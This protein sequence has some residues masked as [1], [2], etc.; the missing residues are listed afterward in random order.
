MRG[1]RGDLAQLLKARFPV[2]Y[3]ESYEEQRVVAEVSA[4]AR[5]AA[6]LR[7]PRTVWTWSATGG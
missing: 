5:D 3:I 4:V 1:F 2:L 6:L 7:T